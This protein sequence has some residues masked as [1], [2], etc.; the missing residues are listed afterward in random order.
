MITDLRYEPNDMQRVPA[1]SYVIV[2]VTED[3]WTRSGKGH[4][5]RTGWTWFHFSFK[6]YL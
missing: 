1:E 4:L 2:Q 3:K 5:M 6:D